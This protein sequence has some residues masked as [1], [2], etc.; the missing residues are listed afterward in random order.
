M[1]QGIIKII[2]QMTSDDIS[3]P[4]T[5]QSKRT[6]A[7]D[8][9]TANAPKAWRARRAGFLLSLGIVQ[10]RATPVMSNGT[11]GY[12]GPRGFSVDGEYSRG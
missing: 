11:G 9:A 1:E 8:G 6:V 7:L 4:E 3:A 10:G 2:Q 5:Q 12:H